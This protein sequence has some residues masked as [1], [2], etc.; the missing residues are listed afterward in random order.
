MHHYKRFATGL[1]SAL[2]AL[3]LCGPSGRAQE[4]A[5]AHPFDA[6]V[7]VTVTDDYVI[8]KS[9]GIPNHPTAQFPNKNNPNTIRPQSYTFYIPRKPRRADKPSRLPMGPIGVAINGI[10][11]YNPFNAEGLDAVTGL[12]AEVFDSCCGHPDM[13]G[14]YHYHKYPVCLK[15]RFHDTPGEHSPL[16]GYAFDGYAIYGPRGENGQPPRDLD[17]CNGHTDAKRGY[18][19]HVSATFPYILG[20][21]RGVVETRNFDAPGLHG[22]QP[23]NGRFRAS[24]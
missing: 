17:N 24:P 3:A 21:Y 13:M 15:T 22:M 12:Y 14:R 19:Y 11:F 6:N 16:I 4:A 18:H 2:A 23:N 1:M 9:D 7:H 20:G 5:P 8:V 10:P